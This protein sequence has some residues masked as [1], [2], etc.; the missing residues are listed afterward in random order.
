M[1]L[2]HLLLFI[3]FIVLFG[4]VKLHAQPKMVSDSTAIELRKPTAEDFANLSNDLNYQYNETRA[5][6]SPWNR[7]I[8]WLQNLIGEWLKESYVEWFLKI[9]ASIAFLLVLYLFINQLS[10]GELKSAMTRRKDRTLLD[11]NFR[12]VTDPNSGL[13]DLLSKSIAKKNYGLAVRYL[14]QKS[15]WLLREKELI[16]WKADKTNHDFLFELGDHPAS[17]SFDR[18]TYFYEYIDYGDFNIDEKRFKTIQK[19]FINFKEA[20][21][22][23][24]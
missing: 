23:N 16:N 15:I 6:L 9:T 8:I 3:S 12:T 20:L 7:F 13:D 24:Y 21:D 17:S 10:K 22:I 18:L 11:L 2:R 14:Y 1:T 4:E 19:V 5:K